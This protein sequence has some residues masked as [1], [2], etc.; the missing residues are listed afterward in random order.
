MCIRDSTYT[1]DEHGGINSEFLFIAD[2]FGAYMVQAMEGDT[3]SEQLAA[4][5]EDA[6]IC[7]MCRCV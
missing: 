4:L 6:F 7:E 5:T 1:M 2:A 3:E